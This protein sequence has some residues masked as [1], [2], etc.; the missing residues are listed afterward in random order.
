M[1]ITEGNLYSFRTVDGYCTGIFE[2]ADACLRLIRFRKVTKMMTYKPEVEWQKAF[3]KEHV[4]SY[5][6]ADA[7]EKVRKE[8]I[9]P[10]MAAG[11]DAEIPAQ[12]IVWDDVVLN[13]DHI[14]E[15]R[16]MKNY[17]QFQ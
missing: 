1:I 2:E 3:E 5:D 12:F 14:D 16:P 6:L 10:L 17:F 8:I 4:P 7:Q 9:E 15:I 13:M 11:K